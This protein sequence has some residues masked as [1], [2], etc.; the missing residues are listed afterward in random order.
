MHAQ[1]LVFCLKATKWS[2]HIACCTCEGSRWGSLYF[3]TWVSTLV[4]RTL[5]LSALHLYLHWGSDGSVEALPSRWCWHGEVVIVWMTILAHFLESL[6]KTTFCIFLVSFCIVHFTDLD[7][8][9]QTSSMCNFFCFAFKVIISLFS[10]YSISRRYSTSWE[11]LRAPQTFSCFSRRCRY[12]IRPSICPIL[13]LI[14]NQ[15]AVAAVFHRATFQFA[16]PL[17]GHH[18][19]NSQ[20]FSSLPQHTSLELKNKKQTCSFICRYFQPNQV[21]CVGI[22]IL[23]GCALLPFEG[24]SS[25]WTNWHNHL[26]HISNSPFQM[27]VKIHLAVLFA[28]SVDER[29]WTRVVLIYWTVVAESVIKR[30]YQC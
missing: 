28:A 3:F 12:V 4:S 18:I 16:A 30:Q 27:W 14:W 26:S 11:R 13:Q 23:L 29:C 7:L 6:I 21:N 22:S 1:L 24:S 9:I 19:A 10:L 20:H 15:V 25:K 5:T 17:V 2:L 8:S